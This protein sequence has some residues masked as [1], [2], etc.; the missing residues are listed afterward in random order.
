MRLQGLT[1]TPLTWS[2]LYAQELAA[3]AAATA[4]LRAELQTV[5]EE[6]KQEISRLWSRINSSAAM[7]MTA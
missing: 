1:P 3:A 2:L 6:D 7:D 4:L 5:Q